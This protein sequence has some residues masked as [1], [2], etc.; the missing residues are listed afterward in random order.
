MSFPGFA[1]LALG[2]PGLVFFGQLARDD[3][4]APTPTPRSGGGY[5]SGSDPRVSLKGHARGGV[6][7]RAWA[8]THHS[9]PT[10]LGRV[11]SFQTEAEPTGASA[12]ASA[13]SIPRSRS[14]GSVWICSLR[15]GFCG[16]REIPGWDPN[17][18][19]HTLD[20]N[21]GCFRFHPWFTPGSSVVVETRVELTRRFWFIFFAPGEIYR[22]SAPLGFFPSPD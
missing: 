7:W 12:E 2:T 6:E 20:G 8:T 9:P 3:G 16:F 17:G 19:L 15:L 21:P 4:V 22:R 10:T 13:S 14:G 5:R 1:G 11:R 18:D